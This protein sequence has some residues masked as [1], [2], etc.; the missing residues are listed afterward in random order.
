[1]LALTATNDSHPERP[2]MPELKLV[3][4][5][6][7]SGDV[8]LVSPYNIPAAPDQGLPGGGEHPDQG[9]PGVPDNTLPTTPPPTLPAGMYLIMVRTPDGKWKWAAVPQQIPPLPDQGLPSVPGFP[10]QGLP[11]M[12]PR[13]DQGLPG[14]PP[15]VGG[16][17]M[18]TPPLQPGQLPGQTPQPKP[19]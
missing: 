11:G 18:P 16:G 12:P 7:V 10:D 1:M 19:A 4:I 9:I 17:P 5:Q 6:K 8:Y 15:H 2:K 13:P 3:R 14:M